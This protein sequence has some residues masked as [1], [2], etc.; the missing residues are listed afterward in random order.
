MGYSFGMQM[1]G[2]KY[3]QANAKYRYGF[4]GKENDNDVKGDGNQQDYGMRIYDPRLGRF[5]SID[6]IMKKYPMLTPYQFASN[7]SID[8]IDQDGLEYIKPIKTFEYNGTIESNPVENIPAAGVNGVIQLINFVPALWNSTVK[9]IEA[10]H[11]GTWQAGISKEV[12]QTITNTSAVVG[13]FVDGFNTPIKQQA[14]NFVNVLNNP[15]TLETGVSFAT[16]F[17]ISAGLKYTGTLLKVEASVPDKLKAANLGNQVHYDPLNGKA[18]LAPALPT[19][20]STQF[21]ETEFS[22]TRRGAKGADVKVTGG[23]HPSAYP[24]SFWDPTNIFGDFK[25][26]NANGAATFKKEIKSGKL[27]AN[28]QMLPY[29]TETG[30]LKKQ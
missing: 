13:N 1:P 8:G 16:P 19:E 11:N 5:L 29:D 30:K 18:S 15:K 6:P 7:R 3:A 20:L 2:R 23:V 9:N 10:I 14:N 26:G 21:P 27:P 22:F 25:P 4:N 12:K 28:T 24:N 17:V